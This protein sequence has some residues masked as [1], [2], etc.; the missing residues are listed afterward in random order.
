[1]SL[2][3]Q[4]LAIR[5]T[6]IWSTEAAGALGLS[7]YSTP[8]SIW[9]EKV[10][11]AAAQNDEEE[12]DEDD[13]EVTQ[14]EAQSMG[15]LLQPVIGQLYSQRTGQQLVDMEG[16]TLYSDKHPF[17]ASHFDYRLQSDRRKLVECK[18]FHSMRRKEFGDEGSGDIPMDCLV[19]C[20]HEGYVAGADVV[21][22]AVLF[23]GQKFEIFTI[24]VEKTAVDRLIERL[25][26]F[27][28][29]VEKREPPA[30][31]TD[32][33]VKALWQRDTGREVIA[34]PEI[35]RACAQ[36]ALIKENLKAGKE[37]KEQLDVQI[38]NAIGE[39]AA[40]RSADRSRILATW[41]NSKDSL[42]FDGKR[43]AVDNPSMY[44]RYTSMVPG[45]RRFLLK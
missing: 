11:Q 34:T 41:K 7:K 13:E 14:T 33:E 24:P 25:Q 8:V 26:A 2:S 32:E 15:L 6:A 19:Q 35:E 23:G 10:G 17:M 45:S 3:A 1:M 39:A 43:F 31:Q 5:S 37:A 28:Q 38:K 21:D 9:M 12:E 42:K 36:L 27:W 20:L 22:L 18:N 30:P 4:D 16:V 44:E 29:H 40:L